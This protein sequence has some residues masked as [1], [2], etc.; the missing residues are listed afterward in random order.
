MQKPP[1]NQNFPKKIEQ[2]AKFLLECID[3]QKNISLFENWISKNLND[4]VAQHKNAFEL[5]MSKRVKDYRLFPTYQA[6]N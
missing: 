3:I 6:E 4:H 2:I 5:K 1:K